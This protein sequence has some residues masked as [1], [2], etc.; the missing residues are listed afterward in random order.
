MCREISCTVEGGTQLAMIYFHVEE[1]NTVCGG[2]QM[3]FWATI[4]RFVELLVRDG[5]LVGHAVT[6]FPSKCVCHGEQSRSAVTSLSL[7]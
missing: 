2:V 7:S 3:H 5:E 6:H 4:N 1:Q